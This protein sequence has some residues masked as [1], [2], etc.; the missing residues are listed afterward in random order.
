MNGIKKKI[1]WTVKNRSWYKRMCRSVWI[2]LRVRSMIERRTC[3]RYRSRFRGNR[4]STMT[5]RRKKD[6]SKGFLQQLASWPTSQAKSSGP[7]EISDSASQNLHDG[8]NDWRSWNR[9]PRRVLRDAITLRSFLSWPGVLKS[10]QST[11]VELFTIRRSR[12]SSS[13]CVFCQRAPPVMWG[14]VH[15]TVVP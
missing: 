10:P 5:G 1:Y 12:Y 14:N 7:G 3:S 13:S 2:G 8:Q 9:E 6:L 11:A 15:V 4:D